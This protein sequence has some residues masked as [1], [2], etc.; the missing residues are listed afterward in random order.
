MKTLLL[1]LLTLTPILAQA[2][3][4]E[5]RGELI[6]RYGQPVE[7]TATGDVFV[8][9]KCIIK[10]PRAIEADTIVYSWRSFDLANNETEAQKLQ[11]DLVEK[12]FGAGAEVSRTELVDTPAIYSHRISMPLGD[13]ESVQTRPVYAK[14]TT[15]KDGKKPARKLLGYAIVEPSGHDEGIKFI[16]MTKAGYER[17]GTEAKNRAKKAQ[18]DE[19][20]RKVED[21]STSGL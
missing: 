11:T 20:K 4:G 10:T 17:L 2:R 12:N 19:N 13:E 7:T 15:E 1:T 5:T 18:D 21:H 14:E 9:G 6:K 8:K 16:L 3:L